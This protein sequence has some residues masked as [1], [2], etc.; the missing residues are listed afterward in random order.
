[1]FHSFFNDCTRV[2]DR[3]AGRAFEVSVVSLRSLV[4]NEDWPNTAQKRLSGFSSVKVNFISIVNRALARD[5][6]RVT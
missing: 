2:S 6:D 1:M 5:N 4:C 3:D